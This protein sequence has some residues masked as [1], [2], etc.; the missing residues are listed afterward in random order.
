MTLPGS[1]DLE[2][3]HALCDKT[4]KDQAVWFLNAFW[5]MCMSLEFEG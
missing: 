2:K 3:L 4:Y 1:N 5:G